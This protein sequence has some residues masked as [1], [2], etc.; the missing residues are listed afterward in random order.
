MCF[1]VL[2]ASGL[3]VVSAEESSEEPESFV[4]LLE[5]GDNLVGWVGETAPIEDLLEAVPQIELMYTWDA[6][7]QRYR[8]AVPGI[9]VSGKA[10]HELTSETSVV[11]R[12][13]EEP[14]AVDRLFAAV[15]EIQLIYR[16]DSIARHWDF[17]LRALGPDHRT[18]EVLAPGTTATIRVGA[19]P[20][21]AQALLEAAPQIDHIFRYDQSND[22][23]AYA[24][25][26]LTPATGGLNVLT[27]EWAL[28]CGS[29]ERNRS[30][31]SGREDRLRAR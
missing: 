5:P 13:G 31:G 4:T 23:Y 10:L 2:L 22:S 9:D 1:A 20:V 28:W 27:P 24:F 11:I 25:P 16:W 12:I 3:A 17:A 19:E 18:L 14:L 15:P 6:E 7:R 21:S 30:S 8:Y 26:G 29:V